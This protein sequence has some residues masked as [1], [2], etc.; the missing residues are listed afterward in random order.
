MIF[1]V[2]EL[3]FEAGAIDG[4]ITIKDRSN[5]KMTYCQFSSILH[6]N[7]ILPLISIKNASLIVQLFFSSF[8]KF[9]SKFYLEKGGKF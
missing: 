1:D 9:F 3:K 7:S 6:I 5:P 4:I 8:I 2:E